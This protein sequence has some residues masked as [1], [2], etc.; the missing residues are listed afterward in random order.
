MNPAGEETIVVGADRSSQTENAQLQPHSASDSVATVESDGLP[1]QFAADEYQEGLQSKELEQDRMKRSLELVGM[2]QMI[3]QMTVDQEKLRKEIA[4]LTAQN[5][6]YQ[7][8]IRSLNEKLN[9]VMATKKKE[10]DPNDDLRKYKDLPIMK[11]S[12]RCWSRAAWFRIY[13][14]VMATNDRHL[15]KYCLLYYLSDDFQSKSFMEYFEKRN[16]EE[17]KLMFLTANE[18]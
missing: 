17:L 18:F 1:S 10:D 13:E 15:L 6:S 9:S 8:E 16:Y 11:M 12:S 3:E 7:N 14:D 5:E 2:K 4:K